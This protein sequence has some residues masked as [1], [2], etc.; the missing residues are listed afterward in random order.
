[1]KKE[2][3]QK[4]EKRHIATEEETEVYTQENKAIN[5]KEL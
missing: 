2:L 5:E 4:T 1:M 3:R